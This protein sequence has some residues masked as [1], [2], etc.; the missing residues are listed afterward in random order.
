MHPDLVIWQVGTNDVL[1]DVD[2]AAAAAVI[3]EGVL[4]MQQAGIDVVLMDVQFAP[5]VTRHATFREMETV[6]AAEGRE[7]GAET[8]ARIAR[9]VL[10]EKPDLV[11]WQIGTN[12]VLNDLDPEKPMRVY[13][14]DPDGSL[15]VAGRHGRS[16]ITC[17]YHFFE[18]L[19][20]MCSITLHRI[21]QVWN[22]VKTFFEKDA[23]ITPAIINFYSCLYKT[24]IHADDPYYKQY[25]YTE[26]DPKCHTV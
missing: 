10:P 20:F 26:G 12:D 13:R 1:R 16:S 8:E 23:Y 17:L 14:I 7:L 15:H 11:I 25:Y 19:A 22:E 24:I 21:H 9:D 4:R 2:P 5:S 6:I 18:R 3:R